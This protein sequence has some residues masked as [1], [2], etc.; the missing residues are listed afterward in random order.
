MACFPWT[1]GVV[2]LVSG[3]GIFS[4]FADKREELDLSGTVNREYVYRSLG[5]SLD[6]SRHD[7]EKLVV[8]L[9]E[10]CREFFPKEGACMF[11]DPC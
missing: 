9:A 11:K 2:L 8:Q 3:D 1:G 6:F 4:L 7:Y 5:I 10:E